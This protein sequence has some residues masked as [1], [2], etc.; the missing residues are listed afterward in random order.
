MYELFM[1]LPLPFFL[2]AEFDEL[3]ALRARVAHL[4]RDVEGLKAIVLNLDNQKREVTR[5]VY[6][7]YLE[8]AREQPFV[9]TDPPEDELVST[10][11]H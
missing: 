4:Q 8:T 5:Q 10:C 7:L 11:V 9:Q 2:S 6:F 1:T 3:M